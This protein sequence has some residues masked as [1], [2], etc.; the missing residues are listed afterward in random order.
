[1]GAGI[2]RSVA[3]SSP[4]PTLGEGSLLGA[5]AEIMGV[6]F[7][8]SAVG[9]KLVPSNKCVA[10]EAA[11]TFD[12]GSDEVL[13]SDAEDEEMTVQQRLSPEKLDAYESDK[14]PDYSPSEASDDS[15]EYDSEAEEVAE[16]VESAVVD[17]DVHST[18]IEKAEVEQELVVVDTESRDIMAEI[19][20]SATRT[21]EDSTEAVDCPS[22]PLIDTQGFAAVSSTVAALEAAVVPE[23]PVT[24][25]ATEEI[26]IV[27]IAEEVQVVED[28]G[29]EIDECN[30]PKCDK[31][32]HAAFRDEQTEDSVTEATEEIEIVDID[33]VGVDEGEVIEE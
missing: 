9:L 30:T 20:D 31:P 25:E 24:N 11:V 3:E 27:D 21:I 14:D 6:N 17:E 10:D 2:R 23:K 28:E 7:F 32:I 19:V 22:T 16:P 29:E 12:M 15:L 13:E 33:E 18:V 4:A 8:L 5:V 26:E 1:M